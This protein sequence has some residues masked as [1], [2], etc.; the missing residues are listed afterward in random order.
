MKIVALYCT[1]VLLMFA[2]PS[3]GAAPPSSEHLQVVIE[4]QVTI[5]SAEANAW[6]RNMTV[7]PN[8]TIWIN[9][10]AYVV[11]GN[12]FGL[13]TDRHCSRARTKARRGPGCR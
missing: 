9:S 8:G 4:K 12:V 3:F 11:K 10:S 13:A 5:A 2:R 1:A 6:A 7:G